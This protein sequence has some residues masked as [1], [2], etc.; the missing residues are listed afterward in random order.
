MVLYAILLQK[1][2]RFRGFFRRLERKKNG[3]Y[4]VTMFYDAMCHHVTMCV[5]ALSFGFVQF[6]PLGINLLDPQRQIQP[7]ENGAGFLIAGL[8]FSG[9]A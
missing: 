6:R 8:G 5:R 9:L 2:P 1:K 4:R 7:I 3:E